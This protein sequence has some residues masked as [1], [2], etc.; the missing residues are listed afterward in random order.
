MPKL[1]LQLVTPERSVVSEEADSISVSTSEGYITILPGHVP[2]VANLV[3]GEM[4]I[5]NGGEEHILHVAGG[6]VQVKAG[7]QVVMLADQAEHFEEIDLQRAE[8]AKLAAEALLRE[9]TLSNEEYAVTA[10]LLQR[11][12]TRIAI[13]RKHAHRKTRITSEGVFHSND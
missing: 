8:K 6:F 7:N 3:S 1:Q 12:L 4:T 10:N 5:R 13:V 2:L 11:N 9:Q